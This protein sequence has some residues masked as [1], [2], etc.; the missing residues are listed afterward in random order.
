MNQKRAHPRGDDKQGFW[1][2]GGVLAGLLVGAVVMWWAASVYH[3]RLGTD[4]AAHLSKQV[5]QMHAEQDDLHARLDVLKGELAVES[6]TRKGLE[7]ALETTQDELGAAR[8]QIAFFYELLP[9]GPEG[10]ISVR[11]LDFQQKGSMLHFRVLLM[12]HGASTE[13]FD[14][15]L[16]FQARGRAAGDPVT[17]ILE[18]V[19]VLTSDYA[20]NVPVNDGSAADTAVGVD[21][22]LDTTEY[23][24]DAAGVSAKTDVAEN[25]SSGLTLA[26]KFEQFQRSSGLLQI[27]QGLELEEVTLNVLEGQTL[28]VSRTVKLPVQQLPH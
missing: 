20:Q 4:M 16:Q 14:G 26:L 17:V 6:S 3:Q 7:I 18:P 10:T 12:R 2:F 1:L 5:Q 24:Q 9:P 19:R 11:G 8:D 15:M 22:E 25:S 27:P 13:D 21:D 23:D 28:R